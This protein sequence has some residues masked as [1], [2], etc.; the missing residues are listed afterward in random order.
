MYEQLTLAPRS[1]V[2]PQNPLQSSILRNFKSNYFLD[3]FC[4]I[5]LLTEKKILKVLNKKKIPK[6]NSSIFKDGKFL[7]YKKVKTYLK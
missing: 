4:P 6:K 1:I 7:I 2:I 3:L 5:N